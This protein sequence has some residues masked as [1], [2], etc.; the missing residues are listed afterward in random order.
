M[1]D[2]KKTGGSHSG[3]HR[4][5]HSHRTAAHRSG[6]HRSSSHSHSHNTSAHRSDAHGNGAHSSSSHHSGR[7]TQHSGYRAEEKVLSKAEATR[8]K[9]RMVISYVLSFILALFF[10]LFTVCLTAMNCLFSE[11][12]FCDVMQ[13]DYYRA[14]LNE[15][16]TEAEDYTIPVG[17]DM[18]VLEGVFTIDDVK[19]D[20]NGNVTAAFRGYDYQPDLTEANVRLYANAAADIAENRVIVEGSMENVINAYI[21]DIDEFYLDKVKIPGMSL[22]EY[23][24]K[25][26]KSGVTA[27]LIILFV[28][29]FVL[30]ATLIRLYHYPHQGMRFVVYATGG[31]AIMMFV[32]P[33][34]LYLSKAYAH[35][36][37]T[38]EYF[39]VFVS[40]YFKQILLSLMKAS[41]LWLL[42][43]IVCAV[44][45]YLSKHGYL[46]GRLTR[47]IRKKLKLRR[48]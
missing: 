41:L 31:C 8:E 44:L 10:T 22:I 30:T 6:T 35:V 25:Y 16:V 48:A 18:S 43:T 13:E 14:V 47:K 46:E 37:V 1:A 33:F 17:L 39:Y 20:I 4:G 23:A 15:I 3:T 9:Y 36:F 2:S 27:A 29:S 34:H 21:A 38:P 5:D 11:G 40:N 45:I 12:F 19:R 32:V 42:V 7:R 28:L 26:V 24:R